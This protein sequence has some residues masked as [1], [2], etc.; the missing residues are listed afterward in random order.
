MC[1]P[2][3]YINV[4][5][6]DEETYKFDPAYNTT[7]TKEDLQRIVVLPEPLNLAMSFLKNETELKKIPCT[8]KC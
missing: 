8:K 5:E 7:L 6:V 4:S 2:E 1:H 3:H